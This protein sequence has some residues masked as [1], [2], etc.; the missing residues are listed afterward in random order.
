MTDHVPSEWR[1]E[2]P[3][4]CTEPGYVVTACKVC[5]ETLFMGET[6]PP[7]GHMIIQ[8]LCTEPTRCVT[9]GEIFAEATG[10]STSAGV[11][12]WCGQTINELFLFA[13]TVYAEAAGQNALTKSAVAHTMYNRIGVKEWK[14]YTTITA[15]I[16]QPYQFSGYNNA[17]Y[18]SAYVYYETG[19]HQNEIERV[20]MDECLAICRAILEGEVDFTGGATFF[21]S[22]EKPE[23]WKYHASYTLLTVEGTEGFWFYV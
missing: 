1:A 7:I 6:V 12:E 18:H 20:A 3:P 19:V 8:G 14:K 13:A 4:T 22:L 10:H 23:D 2:Q 16:T 17:M 9:C 15:V 11:C 5:G 21:H